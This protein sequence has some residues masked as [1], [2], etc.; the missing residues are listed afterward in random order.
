M[1]RSRYEISDDRL[2]KGAFGMVLSAVDSKT[3]QKVACKK[4]ATSNRYEY[5]V[6]MSLRNSKASSVVP[7]P[8]SYSEESDG[9]S[10]L[11]M[12]KMDV[13]LAQLSRDVDMQNDARLLLSVAINL[14]TSLSKLHDAGWLHRDVKPGNIMMRNGS[15]RVYLVD[16]GM[17]KKF[18][19]KDT[20][21]HISFVSKKKTVVGT[22]KYLSLWGHQHMQQSRRDDMASAMYTLAQVANGRLPWARGGKQKPHMEDIQR[23]KR[24]TLPEELF[25]GLPPSFAEV[26]K[27]VMALK[28]YE[29]PAYTR[30]IN[31]FLRD[32][33]RL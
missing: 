32:L 2:G 30:Y 21:E 22:A 13:D 18:R 19:S 8:L 27:R 14:M 26:Q 5:R 23:M 28:F 20:G 9:S 31:I 11:F 24:K 1:R 17:A 15:G 7:E 10:L 25:D 33:K 6:L 12:D 16:F 29:R 3:R 4:Q